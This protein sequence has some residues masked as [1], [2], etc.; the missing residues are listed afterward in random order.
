METKRSACASLAMRVRSSRETK[1]S[2]LRVITTSNPSDFRRAPTLRAMASVR[3]FSRTPRGPMAPVSLPPWPASTTTRLVLRPSCAASEVPEPSAAE[4]SSRALVARAGASSGSVR[5]A[6]ALFTARTM[7]VLRIGGFAGAS[8]SGSSSLSSSSDTSPARALARALASSTICST[9]L[10][11]SDSTSGSLPSLS[12]SPPSASICAGV[13]GGAAGVT[14]GAAGTGGGRQPHGGRQRLHPDGSGIVV[15]HLPQRSD[16]RERISTRPGHLPQLGAGAGTRERGLRRARPVGGRLH[17]AI[18]QP[19]HG[20]PPIAVTPPASVTLELFERRLAGLELPRLHD[21]PRQRPDGGGEERK[22]GDQQERA[23]A[24]KLAEGIDPSIFPPTPTHGYRYLRMPATAK[25]QRE[26]RSASR[27]LRRRADSRARDHASTATMP[28]NTRALI[29]APPR[30]SADPVA[31]G[32]P[33]RAPPS[34]RAD[35][36][37]GSA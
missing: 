8:G 9:A 26:S 3:S 30:R 12:S 19:Q 21:R 25:R 13:R 7:G 14:P 31:R 15:V 2:P 24:R 4:R 1:A 10:A 5:A 35:S 11:A 20:L 23:H 34:T 33:Q 17:R 16:G 22:S 37:T 29:A 27:H 32:P 36:R 28:M 18:E 6:T